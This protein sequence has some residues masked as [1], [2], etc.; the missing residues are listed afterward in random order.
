MKEK[1]KLYITIAILVILLISAL[2]YAAVTGILTFSGIAVISKNVDLNIV[3]ES[4]VGKT[5]GDGQSVSVTNSGHTLTFTVNLE[6]PGVTKTINFKIQNIGSVDAKLASLST[7]APS[8]AA[9]DVTWPSLNGVVV[10]T[11]ET[12]SEYSIDV[13]W[14]T[15]A[16]SEPAG[17]VTFSATINYA[18]DAAT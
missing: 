13:T 6:N 8:D 10:T 2:V 4:I 17:S 15:E 12:S 5:S 16:G 18:E 11:G 3:D 7:T 9:V 14:L 1:K